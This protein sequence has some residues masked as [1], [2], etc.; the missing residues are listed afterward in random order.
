MANPKAQYNFDG[1]EVTTL[2][3]A[4]VVRIPIGIARPPKLAEGKMGIVSTSGGFRTLPGTEPPPGSPGPTGALTLM[5]NL[6]RW[7]TPRVAR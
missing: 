2:P 5:V 3:D 4:I 7:L 1:I 6:G